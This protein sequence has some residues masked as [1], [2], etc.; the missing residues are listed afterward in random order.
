MRVL[1]L[2]ANLDPCDF[3]LE[4]GGRRVPRAGRTGRG[5]PR[6][7]YSTGPRPVRS[8]LGRGLAAGRRVGAGYLEPRSRDR[9]GWGSRSS[10]AK[11]LDR[12]SYRLR[13]PAETLN[14]L[15]RKQRRSRPATPQR[16]RLPAGRSAGRRSSGGESAATRRPAPAPIRPATSIRPIS[17]S[18]RS[19][20]NEPTAFDA[21]DPAH[22]RLALCG[23]P[24][25]GR[26]CRPATTSKPRGRAPVMRT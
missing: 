7:I 14:G 1:T 4:G 18:S 23:T 9:I 3:L 8:R 6:L 17:S 16:R 19:L 24:R 11:A 13:V 20:L 25:C 22:R 21:A 10:N 15:L 5:T 12:L 2:P 26:S